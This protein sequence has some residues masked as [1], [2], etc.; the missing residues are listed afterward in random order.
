MVLGLDRFGASTPGPAL[1]ERFGVT[2][3]H[4]EA[5]LEDLLR[6]PL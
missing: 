6:Q 2:P 3:E 1:F 5:A 4:I